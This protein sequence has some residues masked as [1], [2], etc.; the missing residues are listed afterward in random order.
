M[1]SLGRLWGRFLFQDR[2]I[3]PAKNLLY[4]LLST[5]FVLFI[6]SFFRFD[7]IIFS[8]LILFIV[9]ASLIDLL[10]SPNRRGLDLKREIPEDVERYRE[11]QIKLIFTNQ[12]DRSAFVHWTDD[13]PESVQTQ[14]LGLIEL[15]AGQSLTIQQ[16][17]LA[18]ERGL[19]DLNKVYVR[20]RSRFGLWEKQKTFALEGSLKVIPNLTESRDYLSSAQKYLL[21][22]GSKIRRQREGFGEFSK[23]RQY[24]VG[25]D[26]R[27]INWRQ[28]AKLHEMMVNEYEPEHGK[29]IILMIDCG[30]MM[31][32]ELEKGNRLERSIEAALTVA[33]AALDNGDYVAVVAFGK[34]I[35]AYVPPEKGLSHL[36]TILQAI[37]SLQ[38][39]ANESNYFG[40]FQ[41]IQ[42]EQRR[43]SM[44]ILFSDL[45]QFFLD[46]QSLFYVRRLRKQH[47]FLGLGIK[48]QWKQQTIEQEA[49]S[50]YD[51]M[52]KSVAQQMDLTNRKAM[53]KWR[54]LGLDLIETKADDLAVTSVSYYIDQLNRGML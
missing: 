25:D 45:N 21:H 50:V 31:G 11:D 34:D 41:F 53:I 27:K 47:L 44:V 38:V 54:S 15:K 5:G 28:S 40:A 16:P 26:P 8:G 20:Y 3:L 22:E 17:I 49:D 48:D 2:G 42:A 14:K 37:Y 7:L 23:V 6:I 32:V 18:S 1:T 10:F 13:L 33:T 43:R 30:R 19:F 9:F 36:Q 46:Q 24:A 35:K 52:R 51:A 4:L 29:Q 12:T 39:E